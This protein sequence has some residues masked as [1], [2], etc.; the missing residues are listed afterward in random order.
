MGG[1]PLASEGQ[2]VCVTV[3]ISSALASYAKCPSEIVLQAATVGSALDQLDGNHPSLYRSICDETGAVRR[4][5]N[6]FVN[7]ANILDRE[8]LATQLEPGDV[9]VVLPAV[10]GGS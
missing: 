7:S 4:H 1:R 6:L 2:G 9:I 8:A 10:S 5:L 3:E